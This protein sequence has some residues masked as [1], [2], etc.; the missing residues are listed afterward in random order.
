LFSKQ[1]SATNNL[2]HKT[3][4][5]IHNIRTFF[6]IKKTLKKALTNEEIFVINKA[7]DHLV[8]SHDQDET[9]LG[10]SSV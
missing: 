7:G 2:K 6:Q 8:V 1:R 5:I 10:G 4:K 9:H 3:L